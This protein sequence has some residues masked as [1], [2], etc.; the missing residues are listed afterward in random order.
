MVSRKKVLWI[1]PFA[2]YDSV[3]HAGG[4]THNFYIKHF[5]KSGFFDITLFS[6]CYKNEVEK[7]VLEQ[8]GI[9]CDIDVQDETTLK[10]IF[11]IMNNVES[12]FNPWNRYC[13]ILLGYTRKVLTRKIKK[14]AREGEQPEII[15]LQWTAVIFLYPII[16]K[17]FPNSKLVA[18]EE[19]V[20]YLA[21]ER[22]A[23]YAKSFY[24]RWLCQYQYKKIKAMELDALKQMDFVVVNNPKDESLLHKENLFNN[25]IYRVAPFYQRSDYSWKGGT[26]N[27]IFYGAMNREENYLSAIWFAENVLSQVEDPDV[28]F[29]IIGGNPHPSLSKIEDSRVEITGFVDDVKEYFEKCLCLVAP[30]VLG[31]GIKVK[32][33]EA[34]DA[35]IPVLTNTIGIEGISAKPGN[36]YIHCERAEEYVEIVQQILS[37]Q[38]DTYRLS[39]NAKN[40]MKQEYDIEKTL[41]KL[42]EQLR[43]T[44]E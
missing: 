14:M 11:R 27:I 17:V 15:I 28:R 24:R 34:L 25:R 10:T 4:K 21:F 18:I 31:A 37:E 23:S 19:D 20:T 5:Q 3:G 43:R 36:E 12:V 33:L 44:L 39:V 40:F 41:D 16:K 42:I 9:S 32:I 2:P 29:V 35:G 6:F 26:K 1:S 30:L 8:C 38:L 22:K 13:N 7:I